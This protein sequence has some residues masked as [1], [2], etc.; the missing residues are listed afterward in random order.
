MPIWDIPLLIHSAFVS[1]IISANNSLIRSKA[2]ELR[3]Q[4]NKRRGVSELTQSFCFLDFRT[5][6]GRWCRPINVFFFTQRALPFYSLV[7]FDWSPFFIFVQN[8]RLITRDHFGNRIERTPS[9]I[10]YCYSDLP[11]D[12]LLPWEVRCIVFHWSSGMVYRSHPYLTYRVESKIRRL[13]HKTGRS[14]E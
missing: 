6:L 7:T 9:W 3:L 8:D 5:R 2:K 1:N 13:L 4:S 12:N 14:E 11:F 10:L